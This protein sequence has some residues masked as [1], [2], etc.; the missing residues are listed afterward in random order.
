MQVWG[1]EGKTKLE[2]FRKQNEFEAH[3]Q[4]FKLEQLNWKEE[5]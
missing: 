2:E 5:L 4:M 3:I 1:R